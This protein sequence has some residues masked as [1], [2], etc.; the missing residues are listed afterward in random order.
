MSSGF[1]TET[2]IEAKRLQ[3]QAEWEKV[4]KPEDPEGK[5]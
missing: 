4:R 3:R 2:E 5:K 1:I